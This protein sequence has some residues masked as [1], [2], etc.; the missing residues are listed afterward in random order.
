MQWFV[1]IL[2]TIGL[3]A[4]MALPVVTFC[5]THNPLS[6]SLFGTL[7]PPT[8][9]VFY[10]V[11]YVLPRREKDYKL[12]EAKMKYAVQIAEAKAKYAVQDQTTRRKAS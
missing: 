1:F 5:L 3:I 11:K 9:L 10:I 8:Y 2:V 12:A 7:M 6:F 4:A